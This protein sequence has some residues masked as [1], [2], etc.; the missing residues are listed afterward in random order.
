MDYS[1]LDFSNE[2]GWVSEQTIDIDKANNTATKV[3]EAQ[4]Y[5]TMRQV[6]DCLCGRSFDEVI[7][8]DVQIWKPK[9]TTNTEWAY[10]L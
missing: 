2:E 10:P 3:V 1:W 4:G 6:I 8:Y 5:I 9:T 7:D